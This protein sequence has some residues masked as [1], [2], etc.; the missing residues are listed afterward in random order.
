MKLN[1]YNYQNHIYNEVELPDLNYKTY[2]S[3]MKEI[4]TCPQ[5]LQDLIYGQSYTSLEFHDNCGMGYGVCSDCYEQEW[6]R[7]KEA[8]FPENNDLE[9]DIED[10]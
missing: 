3:D 7:R 9:E 2:C 4:I 10:I 6:N 1:K 5:C 8:E